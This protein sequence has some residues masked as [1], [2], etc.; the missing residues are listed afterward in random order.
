MNARQSSCAVQSVASERIKPS[1]HTSHPTPDARRQSLPSRHTPSKTTPAPL[2]RHHS[3][4]HRVHNAPNASVHATHA[5]VA[6]RNPSGHATTPRLLRRVRCRAPCM[7]V[8]VCRPRADVARCLVAAL[9][10]VGVVTGDTRRPFGCLTVGALQ[11]VVERDKLSGACQDVT[12]RRAGESVVGAQERRPVDDAAACVLRARPHASRAVANA[13]AQSKQRVASVSA[14]CSTGA[15]HSDGHF[16]KNKS[17]S[18]RTSTRRDGAPRPAHNETRPASLCARLSSAVRPAVK[19][20][21]APARNALAVCASR[22][23]R[24]PRADVTNN[25]SSRGPLFYF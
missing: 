1:S 7:P 17:P 3:P 19:D 9:R 18:R 20:N 10:A 4:S 8:R 12:F 5:P 21:V 2:A 11:G 15:C 6:R 23:R 16:P 13:S 22:A 25:H 14:Q 24:R